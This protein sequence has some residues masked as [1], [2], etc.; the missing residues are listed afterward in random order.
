M[1]HVIVK[2]YAGK[3]EAQKARI[4]DE[5]TRAVMAS[6]G[7]GEQ[8]VSVTVEDVDPKDWVETVYKPDIVGGADR[9]Y[10]KPG[11]DPLR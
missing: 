2:L 7:C 1:P 10:K 6:T 3:S 8:A 9:L 5:V 11:Y 4:A